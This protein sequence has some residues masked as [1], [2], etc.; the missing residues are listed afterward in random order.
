M[1]NEAQ[2]EADAALLSPVCRSST[3]SATTTSGPTSG[4]GL[5]GEAQVPADPGQ[6]ASRRPRV[7][8]NGMRLLIHAVEAKRTLGAIATTTDGSTTS[9]GCRDYLVRRGNA[10][11]L[12]VPRAKQPER[13]LQAWRVQR[14]AR[15]APSSWY[16]CLS[17][18]PLILR[19][20]LEIDR[21][22]A[23]PGRRLDMRPLTD[24]DA[25]V[26]RAGSLVWLLHGQEP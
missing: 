7:A 10:A 22:P 24:R 17:V 23:V 14:A 19:H 1:R 20:D 15:L 12:R 2:S 6:E 8:S 13:A 18:T 16:L 4:A 26:S 11:E 9:R 21:R 3:S 5:A 25:H